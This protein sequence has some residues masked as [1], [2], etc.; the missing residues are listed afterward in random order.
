MK[1]QHAPIANLYQR[2]SPAV[3]SVGDQYQIPNPK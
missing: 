3:N 2:N 1:M